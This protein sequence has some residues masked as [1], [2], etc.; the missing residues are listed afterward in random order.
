MASIGQVPP[1]GRS[2]DPTIGADF[3]LQRNFSGAEARGFLTELFH[4]A[5]D[6][7]GVELEVHSPGRRGERSHGKASIAIL[8]EAEVRKNMKI[9]AGLKLKEVFQDLNEA[10]PS[11]TRPLH[12][13]ADTLEVTRNS[14]ND[15]SYL[16]R[17][18]PPYEVE[19]QIDMER[20]GCET[21]LADLTEAEYHDFC[22]AELDSGILLA[23]IGPVIS[24]RRSS[25]SMPSL[26]TRCSE[27]FAEA[28]A[29]RLEPSME[30]LARLDPAFNTS[31]VRKLS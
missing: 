24:A 5:S 15:G 28:L 14:A 4:V 8:S 12:M 13:T 22:W 9:L 6:Y 31:T 18:H 11:L 1:V 23:K 25:A 7:D 21:V 26:D 30:F 27:A 10:V 3:K 19:K 29:L 17:L 2:R 20:E 16:L